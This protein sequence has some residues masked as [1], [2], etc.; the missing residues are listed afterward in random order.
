MKTLPVRRLALVLLLSSSLIWGCNPPA[1]GGSAG[2]G[3]T[4]SPAASGAP[5]TPGKVETTDVKVGDGPSVD[6]AGGVSAEIKVWQDK[7]DGKPFGRGTMQVTLAPE[8]TPL[9]GL[10]NGIKGMKKGGV[11]RIE[12]AAKDLFAK[13]PPGAPL[14]PDQ[15]FFLEVKV[16]DVYPAEPF[17]IKTVKE[18]SGDKAAAEGDVLKVHYVG[19]TEGYDSKKI[20]DSSREKGTPF[21]LKLGDGR[22]IPGWEK[23]LIG[24]KKG[25]LRRLSIPHYLAYGDHA[26]GDKI[27]AKSRLYFE[28]ELLDFMG[29]G[30][31]VKKTTKPGKGQPIAAGQTGNF[32]YT[33]WLDGFNGKKKFDSSKDRG[34]PIPVKL[35]AGQVIQGWDQGLVGM[36][37]GE[38]RQLE[39]PYN[40]AYGEQGRPPHIPPYSTLYFEVEYVGPVAAPTPGA[41][42]TPG[43][44]AGK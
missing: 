21:V 17:E 18:G 3:G 9:P 38:V 25:E 8:T 7:F 11:R 24:M 23:G 1:S 6:G 14:T 34:T 26:Q 19:R 10:L 20:F 29:Q 28:V 39:I 43:K 2:A 33:G 22:V 41:T 32:H 30:E 42:V 16:L 5:A 12:L 44:P 13:I 31:L 40:L 27:P 35:G 36:L 15:K 4:P 37:P